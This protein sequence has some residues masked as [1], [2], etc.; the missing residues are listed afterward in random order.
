[1]TA[2]REARSNS[3]LVHLRL[4]TDSDISPARPSYHGRG[5]DRHLKWLTNGILALS[6]LG[7]ATGGV[8][9]VIESS[10]DSAIAADIQ[11]YGANP[12]SHIPGMITSTAELDRDERIVAHT[13]DIVDIYL[14]E[15]VI[16][17]VA[18]FATG[19]GVSSLENPRLRQG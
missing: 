12:N 3:P 1:M 19:L 13:H 7:I 5:R 2:S 17:S 10:H 6:A 14:I 4:V 11:A 15:S 18:L 9:G 16:S 8:G